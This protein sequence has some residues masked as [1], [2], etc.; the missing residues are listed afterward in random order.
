MSTHSHEE[1]AASVHPPELPSSPISGEPDGSLGPDVGLT[2]A[3][4]IEDFAAENDLPLTDVVAW[5]SQIDESLA[6]EAELATS[7]PPDHFSTSEDRIRYASD[8]ALIA[9][10][11]RLVRAAVDRLSER[12]PAPRGDTDGNI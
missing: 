10:G 3:D 8:I 5:L 11:R 1:T 6:R 2:F 7:N 12:I 4:G 9:G